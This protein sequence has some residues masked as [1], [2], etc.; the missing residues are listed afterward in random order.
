MLALGKGGTPQFVMGAGASEDQKTVSVLPAGLGETT[1]S[2]E[3]LTRNRVTATM[4][5]TSEGTQYRIRRPRETDG[6]WASQ[7]KI[8]LSL[9]ALK[10]LVPEGD[11]MDVFENLVA[12]ATDDS[13]YVVGLVYQN[14]LGSFVR[15]SGDWV[16]LSADNDTYEDASIFRID[17]EGAKAFIDLYDRNHVSISDVQKYEVAVESS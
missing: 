14:S 15:E 2:T 10:G 5:F 16:L 7:Y 6:L 13:P 12:Y 9:P 1:F 4:E 8:I 3:D 17:P 11:N